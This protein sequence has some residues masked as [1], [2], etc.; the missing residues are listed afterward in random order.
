[1]SLIITFGFIIG[2]MMGLV[3]WSFQRGFVSYLQ[4]QEVQKVGQLAQQLALLYSQNE[5]HEGTLSWGFM[6][7]NFGVWHQALVSAFIDS[8]PAPPSFHEPPLGMKLR[9]LERPGAKY[10]TDE[11]RPLGHR[12]HLVDLQKNHAFAL[13][14]SLKPQ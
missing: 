10:P 5:L 14:S 4:Q 6:H 7:G 13:N 9:S 11:G 2:L 3:N 12:I 8:P 1:V